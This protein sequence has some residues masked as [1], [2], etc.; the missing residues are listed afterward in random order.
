[1][2][3]QIIG[4][5]LAYQR[6][7]KGYTQDILSEKS[8]VAIR[9]IQRIEKDQ[10][11]P[12]LQTIKLLADALEIEVDDL[13][14]LENPK[15]EALQNK[16]LLFLHGSPLLGFI[17]PFS[18][19]FPL[20]IWLHK[21]DDHPIYNQHGIKVINFQL[22]ITIVYMLA[23]ISL[24]TVEGWGFLFFITVVPFYILVLTYNIFKA[25][26]AQKCYYPLSFPFLKTTTKKHLKKPFPFLFM[27]AILAVGC[28]SPKEKSEYDQL[29]EY[30]GTYEYVHKSTLD[31]MA[32]E[33]DTTLYAVIDKAKYPLK[34]IALDSFANIQN[35]PVVF[36][37]DNS[38][39]VTGYRTDGIAFKL[40][41][42]EI[43]K[44]EL[45][46]RK[47]LFYNPDNYVYRTP[48]KTTDGLE[49]GSLKDEFKNPKLIIDMV[50]ATIKGE[51]PDVHS[52][53]IY[54]NNKLVLEEYFYGY[55]KNTP[56]QVRS[57]T[58]PFIGGILGIAVD[59]GFIKSEKENLLPYFKSTYPEIANLD[60]RKKEI[61]IENFLRYRHGM[62]CENN[63]PE[64]K[65][66]EQAM[67]ES[68]D[69]VKYTLDLPMVKES[70]KS[71]SYCTGCA[72]TLG[73]LVEVATYKNIEDF[74]KENLFNPLG[75]S[76]YDWTFEPNQAS[77]KTF[78]QMYLTSRDLIKLAKL[79]K[80]GGKWEGKQLISESWIDKTF[81]MKDSEYGYVW[82]K[83]YVDI[84]GERYRSYMA[85]G[86]GGQKINI[87]P[88]LDM[89]TVFTGGNYNSYQLYGKSTAPNEMI[90]NYILKAGG[91]PADKKC[92]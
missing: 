86:N 80:D 70:G 72:L 7:L 49:T 48:T 36:E 63:N 40:I 92:I 12:Q 74:A 25:I 59:K 91:K 35:V 51:F 90:P 23:F 50:K 18:V 33:L 39:R 15:E 44:M 67:M 31:I 13:I 89:I 3:K 37:R 60:D 14:I 16:W 69:W 46:P 53:L 38:N 5:K 85:S 4:K 10:V 8:N 24:V 66:N 58:K 79:F 34:H 27:T 65:G 17:F 30:E 43:E 32:S 77:M 42:S 41:S 1:M 2:E 64:S 56:H 21:R 81:D 83:K 71:S 26:T 9:T 45:Y 82:Y 20:F 76:N 87:W 61:T 6:K 68:K 78:S 73:S 55:D 57:A 75:I 22:S 11:N 88:Q 29:L 19:L 47:E 84:E 54:K 62:D 28:S 52:I